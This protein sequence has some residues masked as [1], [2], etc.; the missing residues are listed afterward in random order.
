MKITDHAQPQ[1]PRSYDGNRDLQKTM[2]EE[3]LPTILWQC[4]SNRTA[5]PYPKNLS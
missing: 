3:R 1:I 5:V 4:G 2:P